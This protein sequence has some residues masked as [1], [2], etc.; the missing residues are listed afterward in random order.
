[1]SSGSASDSKLKKLEII[2]FNDNKF[3]NKRKTINVMMNPS[4]ITHSH[5]INYFNEQPP[6]TIAKENKFKNI[7]PETISFDLVIDGT[8]ATGEI[9]NVHDE[10][11][12]FKDACYNYIGEN[13]ETPFVQLIWGDSFD[14]KGRMK[15]M[16]IT[17][18]MFAPDG[19]SLRAKM[20]VTFEN[21]MDAET[22]AKK[23]GKSSPDLSHLIT[24]KMGDNLPMLCQKVYGDSSYYLQVAR[25]NNL[26]NFRNLTPGDELVFPP[27]KK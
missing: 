6:D 3:E 24:V 26:V 18:T 10:I 20:K 23:M 21:S 16:E 5:G 13:H 7:G 17:H 14:F 9:R 2:S 25:I 12:K 15:S 8:G 19:T 27:V 22:Q 1:M 11:E 4:S